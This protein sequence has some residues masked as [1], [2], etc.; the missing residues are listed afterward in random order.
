LRSSLIAQLV[1]LC[2]AALLVAPSRGEIPTAP[3][4]AVADVRAAAWGHELTQR[5]PDPGVR[6]G[7]LA[8]VSAAPAPVVGVWPYTDLG[9]AT[10]IVERSIDDELGTTTVR[11]AN[12][13]RMM[14]KPTAQEK[15][16]IGVHVALGQGASGIPLNKAHAN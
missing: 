2:A 13:T 4:R 15:N 9:T 7:R 12:S 14:V 5:Q 8:T 6:F 11:F 10:A 16:R 3:S 1:F